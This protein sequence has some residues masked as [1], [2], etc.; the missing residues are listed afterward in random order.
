MLK[1]D[2][3]DLPEFRELAQMV[4]ETRVD[5]DVQLPNTEVYKKI[6]SVIGAGI[7]AAIG[8]A[9]SVAGGPI[10]VAIGAGLGGEIGRILGEELGRLAANVVAQLDPLAQ[11]LGGIENVRDI[12]ISEQRIEA[13]NRSIDRL[14]DF[15]DDLDQ[16]VF[17]LLSQ[18]K[19]N[20]ASPLVSTSQFVRRQLADRFV[21]LANEE[22][23][24][25]QLR[26]QERKALD[27]PRSRAGG[28]V[29]FDWEGLAT[30][31]RSI[32]GFLEEAGLL[33]KALGVE[34]GGAAGALREL[35]NAVSGGGARAD[36]DADVGFTPV[37]LSGGAANGKS[38]IPSVQ[39]QNVVPLLQDMRQVAGDVGAVITGSMLP[40]I[41]IVARETEKGR[42][43]FEDLERAARQAGRTIL[44]TLESGIRSGEKFSDILKR[45]GFQLLEILGRN[46]QSGFEKALDS[47][48]G[49]GILD[50]LGDIIGNILPF[51]EGGKLPIGRL[52][53]V[54]ENG[55][56]L[57]FAGPT[58]VDI[59]PIAAAAANLRTSFPSADRLGGGGGGVRVVINQAFDLRGA[60]PGSA[61]RLQAQAAVIK[62]ETVAEAVAAVR[63]EVLR[64][65]QFAKDMGRR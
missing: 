25:E 40:P 15:L 28:L 52:G 29:G 32:P 61:A 49:G 35:S 57:A 54:G 56:E 59:A 58:G 37:S 16:K 36:S 18:G 14:S 21:K 33:V 4:S 42:D 62:R 17:E 23:R 20:E 45:I 5:I 8:G 24:L 34:A 46:V 60:D 31:L 55:P 6:G 63:G 30:A 11:R 7:G 51:A 43:A 53:L 2:Q 3:K 44:N 65:G 41:S 50:G 1:R 9:L 12:E 38:V 13:E 26:D 19:E 64:G 48:G 27:D 10:G 22:V 47:S 39:V